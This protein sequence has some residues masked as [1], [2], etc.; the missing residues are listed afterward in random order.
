MPRGYKVEVF[1]RDLNFPTDVVFLGNRHDFKVLVLKSGTGLP[2]RCNNNAAVPGIGRFDPRNPFTPGLSIFN[3]RGRRLAGPLGKPTASGGGFQPDGPAIGLS[4]EHDTQGGT[5]F[6]SDSNQGVRGAPGDANNTSRIVRVN[7][8]TG[9]VTPVITGLPTGDHPTEQIVVKDGWLDWSQ[10]SATN[11]GVTGHDNGGGGNQH[12]IACERMT[13][14]RK[15]WDSGDGHKTSGYSTMARRRPGTLVPAF[16]SAHAAGMCDGAILRAKIGT[17][18]PVSTMEP[19]AWGY[20]T[21]TGCASRRRTSAEGRAAD[22]R[23]R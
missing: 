15:R 20:R 4:F 8:N 5:L 19:L 2:G 14:S 23:E 11:A 7:V 17:N 1:A 22:D 3:D 10:G 18:D 6:A 21:R 13:L 16:E 12:E 9:A